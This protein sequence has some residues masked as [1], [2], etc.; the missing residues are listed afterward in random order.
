VYEDLKAFHD[1]RYSCFSELI[2]A[3]FDDALPYFE[4]GSIDLLHIDRLHT[5]EAVRHDFETWR[6]KL[7]PRAV[8]LF[9]DTNVRE[10]NFGVFRLFGDLSKQYPSF[11]F[12]H[13]HGLGVLA[14]GPEAP[15]PIQELCALRDPSLA[16][17]VR[18]RF[19]RLG[20]LW[21]CVSNRMAAAQPESAPAA[22]TPEKRVVGWS[23]AFRR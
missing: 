7:S 5:Y 4:P 21:E 3:K 20:S 18:E 23:W 11:E 19:S 17:A 16:L 1:G 9:H 10:R 15:P 6:P 13:G 22:A 12:L 14:F 2:R 8:V